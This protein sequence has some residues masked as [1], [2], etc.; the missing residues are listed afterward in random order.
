[1]NTDTPR[2]D[3]LQSPTDAQR[4]DYLEVWNNT[5]G[6]IV[7]SLLPVVV[8]QQIPS[9]I[10]QVAWQ[11]YRAGLKSNLNVELERENTQLK[12]RVQELEAEIQT[13]VNAGRIE[14]ELNQRKSECELNQLR[15]ENALAV[16]CVELLRGNFSEGVQE[17]ALAAYDQFKQEQK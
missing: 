17:Q 2:T 6:V 11:A 9:L 8:P 15:A 5:L 13:M 14:I 12:A 1:M 10:D 16:K 4:K 7:D 3:G